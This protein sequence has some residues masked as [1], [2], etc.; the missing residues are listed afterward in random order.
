[1]LTGASENYMRQAFHG[2]NNQ[3]SRRI[4]GYSLQA[5]HVW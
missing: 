5:R 1:M 3:A 4:V 2:S